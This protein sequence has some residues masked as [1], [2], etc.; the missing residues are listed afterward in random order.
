MRAIIILLLGFWNVSAAITNIRVTGTTPTQAVLSYTAPDGAACALEVYDM[1]GMKGG[2]LSVTAATNATPIEITTQYD[3]YL[4]T[5]DRVYVSGVGGN[6]NANGY[7]TVTVTGVRS[8]QLNG[9]AAGGAYSSGGTVAI[10][11]H[12]VN[13]RLFAGADQD[14]RA[15]NTAGGRERTFV[16]GKRAAEKA[17]DN[18]WYSRALQ[19]NTD[20]RYRLRCGADEAEGDFRT[21]NIGLGSPIYDV[22][23]AEAS[24]PNGTAWPTIDFSSVSWPGPNP[25]TTSGTAVSS[26]AHGLA[27]GDLIALTS[28]TL[29]GT[30]RRVTAVSDGNHFTINAAF[31]SNQTN[32]TWAKL[33]PTKTA[34][35]QTIIDPQSGVL[36]RRM[37]GIRRL[38]VRTITGGRDAW[39]DS[40]GWSNTAGA[41]ADDGASASYTGT[42]SGA[43]PWLTITSNT[44][45]PTYDVAHNE[46]GNDGVFNS[47]AWISIVLKGTASTTGPNGS[48]DVCLSKDGVSCFTRTVTQD[49]SGCASGCQ[50]G[51]SLEPVL[52]FW[53]DPA[54]P[55]ATQIPRNDVYGRTGTATWNAAAKR[56]T[57]VSSQ[58][59]FNLNWKP[60]SRITV[61]GVPRVI[62][63]VDSQYQLTLEDG[64]AADG[65]YP[66]AA[67]NFSVLVRKTTN[68][69]DTVRV[70]Y[71]S[72]YLGVAQAEN[73]LYTGGDRCS[74]VKVTQTYN[75]VSRDGYVCMAW[76]SG[77]NNLHWVDPVT[78][79]TTYLTE[80]YFPGGS[81]QGRTWSA[82]ACS[83]AGTPSADL[84][85]PRRMYCSA[86]LS[87]GGYGVIEVTYTGSMLEQA[88][89]Y[90]TWG[91]VTER[92]V[93]AGGKATDELIQEFLT[94]R[95]YSGAPFKTNQGNCGVKSVYS[96]YVS[97]A[98]QFSIQ[99][100]MGWMAVMDV[101]TGQIVGA[102]A[103]H[104]SP[105]FRFCAIHGNGL[106][107]SYAENKVYEHA[108]LKGMS[109]G[110]SSCGGGPWQ[111]EI[112]SGL[113]MPPS[114][115]VACPA[116]QPWEESTGANPRTCTEITVSGDVYDP[117][118]CSDSSMETS[119]RGDASGIPWLGVRPGD[120]FSKPSQN[121]QD[122]FFQV[123]AVNGNKWTVLRGVYGS[124]IQAMTP[125]AVIYGHCGVAKYALSIN[126]AAMVQWD[127][128]V[129]PLGQDVSK[130]YWIESSHYI[131]KFD[132]RINE[133]YKL[134]EGTP[135]D[136]AV[137]YAARAYRTITFDPPFAGKLGNPGSDTHPSMGQYEASLPF[138]LDQ[139]PLYA[140][141]RRGNFA[142]SA[143]SAPLYSMNPGLNRKYFPT[144]AF[145]G[146]RPLVDV[147]G[148]GSK[149]TSAAGDNYKYCVIDR[150]AATE[151][152]DGNGNPY[153]GAA[154][155]KVLF[156]CPYLTSTTSGCGSQMDGTNDSV[157]ACIADANARFD[158]AYQLGIGPVG[159]GNDGAGRWSR[160][161]SRMLGY[162]HRQSSYAN[163]VA[164]PDASWALGY[165]MLAGGTENMA[166]GVKLPPYPL[167]DGPASPGA[168]LPIPVHVGTAPAGTDNV[169]VEFG[170]DPEFHCT[171]RGEA[172]VSA[173]GG[174]TEQPVNE[175]L[176]FY[177]ASESYA[178]VPCANGCTVTLPTLPQ[179]VLY[180]RVKY[181]KADGTVLATGRTE[182]QTT[183]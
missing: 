113:P 90:P 100:T 102:V 43:T 177:W 89:E 27:V 181:R 49:L 97:I 52:K 55:T 3:H 142:V 122:E 25:L 98:C 138:A 30:S 158:T 58:Q 88:Y 129:N 149:I 72:F 109:P 172:C 62:A 165:T 24:A 95:N 179:R 115:N 173:T 78:G 71:A 2:G 159:G 85:N 155:G 180:R 28:G 112:T 119:A 162:P 19:V 175:A 83:F 37:S 6:T 92:L 34:S 166:L 124:T 80:T 32:Q 9:S 51:N 53:E 18:R 110:T 176:P 45:A 170:Y 134:T 48:V 152:T 50:I 57:I 68:S 128:L 178:G 107:P 46:I 156:N 8:F 104:G 161:L 16:I 151:C 169:V 164:L 148:P 1:T 86:P 139:S 70:Q 114:G 132:R 168:F 79:D 91:Q 143:I 171:S 135:A 108:N 77:D 130:L 150:D 21:A 40:S 127:P 12:D 75:G 145:C 84:T 69:A 120:I 118:P 7:W 35:A 60:G 103:S 101:G 87:G 96:H 154:A 105:P 17:A 111:T 99:D 147:S 26:N 116:P 42:G 157:T 73:I 174:A 59:A 64:P 137:Q 82:F 39:D 23:P 125:N 121:Y 160:T 5:G 4:T 11:I 94:A 76:N 54:N 153:P 41:I 140:N 133:G 144:M 13:T 106:L 182:I 36:L 10:L 67:S 14:T 33:D 117:S 167:D 123:L 163:L 183:P 22:W 131:S 44:T 38:P 136:Q 31:S 74:P 65:S 66:Y 20:H 141:P 15:G 93:N 56:L 47:V 63:S 81:D 29:M 61:D 146:R 126:T